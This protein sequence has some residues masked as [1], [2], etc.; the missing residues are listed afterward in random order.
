MDYLVLW[1]ISSLNLCCVSHLLLL[2][3]FCN[4]P[5]SFRGLATLLPFISEVFPHTWMVCSSNQVLT[6]K[7]IN[8]QSLRIEADA[9]ESDDQDLGSTPLRL[10]TNQGRIRIALKR[11]VLIHFFHSFI[12]LSSIKNH[13]GDLFLIAV[14]LSQVKVHSSFFCVD[15]GLQCAGVQAVFHSGWP[16][17]GSDGLPAQGHHPLCQISQ[18]GYGE[19]CPAEKKQDCWILTGAASFLLVTE[20]N[21]QTYMIYMLQDCL[22]LMLW[23]YPGK[24]ILISSLF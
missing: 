3:V 5:R 1:V 17:V 6:F 9:I 24:E 20:K 10:I 15:K 7:E 13:R 21:P 8:W 16:V 11:R 23:D 14:Y 2:W 4:S 22:S 19:V 18:W 12:F